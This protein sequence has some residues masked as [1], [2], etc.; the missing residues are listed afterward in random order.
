MKW[1]YYVK[2]TVEYHKKNKLCKN[3]TLYSDGTTLYQ[4]DPMSRLHHICNGPANRYFED[5]S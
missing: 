5:H 2:I 3:I 4:G 1:R